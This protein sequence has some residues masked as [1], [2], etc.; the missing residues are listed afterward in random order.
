ML[1]RR[2]LDWTPRFQPIADA[3]GEAQGERRLHRRRA[4]RL[5]GPVLAAGAFS[6]GDRTKPRLWAIVLGLLGLL[7]LGLL[8][9]AR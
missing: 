5:S 2:G 9:D 3:L 7:V 8:F 1:T 4:Y 6:W